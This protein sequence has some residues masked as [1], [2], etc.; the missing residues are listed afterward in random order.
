M[1]L[2]EAILKALATG[3][4]ILLMRTMAHID[5]TLQAL[6]HLGIDTKTLMESGRLATRENSFYYEVGKEK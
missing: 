3:S 5:S 6:S 1:V 2:V 4:G